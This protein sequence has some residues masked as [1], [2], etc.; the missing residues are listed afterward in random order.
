MHEKANKEATE[1]AGPK[2]R[3]DKSFILISNV[4]TRYSDSFTSGKA[5]KW[6]CVSE[7]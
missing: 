1:I 5:V 2:V 4:K 7:S 3:E 6:C